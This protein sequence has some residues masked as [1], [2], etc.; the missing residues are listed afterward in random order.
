[1]NIVGQ[2]LLYVS[3]LLTLWDKDVVIFTYLV[4]YG[5]CSVKKGVS[6]IFPGKRCTTT[7]S[8][9]CSCVRTKKFLLTVTTFDCNFHIQ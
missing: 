6:A 1:M 4:L 2:C 5:M 7:I 9:R 8:L 3:V